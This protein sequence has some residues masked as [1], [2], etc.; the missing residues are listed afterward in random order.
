MEGATYFMIYDS[1]CLA[2]IAEATDL[3]LD[4]LKNKLSEIQP[5][6]MAP[7]W[8]KEGRAIIDMP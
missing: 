8:L 5:G 1:R 6:N 7:D 3:F 4:G 2:K